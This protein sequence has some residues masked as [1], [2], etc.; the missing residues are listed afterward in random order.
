ME[1]DEFATRLSLTTLIF[2]LYSAILKTT[3]MILA[4]PQLAEKI[5][6]IFD[7]YL[8]YRPEWMAMWEAGE[9]GC[10]V[11]R[12]WRAREHLLATDFCGKHSASKPRLKANRVPSFTVAP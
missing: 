3:K 10:W 11:G 4:V 9:P 1:V 5:A 8:V 7:G 6:D 12:W 2:F